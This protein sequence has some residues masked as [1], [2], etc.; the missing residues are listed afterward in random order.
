MLGLRKYLVF[1]IFL[2]SLCA[3]GQGSLDDFCDKAELFIMDYRFNEAEKVLSS[4]TE[5]KDNCRGCD[6]KRVAVK[7]FPEKL[8]HGC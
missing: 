1:A 2:C 5:D 3:S 7:S 8:R 4:V 6:L